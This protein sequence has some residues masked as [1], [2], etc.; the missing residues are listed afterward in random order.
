[1]TEQL[2]SGFVLVAGLFVAAAFTGYL[3]LN[4]GEDHASDARHGGPLLR[5]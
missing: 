1:M 3:L 5:G 2:V 4:R